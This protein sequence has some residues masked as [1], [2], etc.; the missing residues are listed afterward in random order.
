MKTRRKK[1]K[2]KK[3]KTKQKHYTRLLHLTFLR[4]FGKC[5]DFQENN[6]L[7]YIRIVKCLGLNH[8][9]N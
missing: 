6:H 1:R 4:R 9:K 5:V 7:F 8:T 3:D 2:K